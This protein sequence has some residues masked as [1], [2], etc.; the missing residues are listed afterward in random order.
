MEIKIPDKTAADLKAMLAR[1]GEDCDL[2]TYIQRTL[3]KRLLF[4]AVGEMRASTSEVDS[5]ELADAIE[6]AVTT[7]RQAHRE[8][9]P[10]ADSA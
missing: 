2:E 7:T 1:R 5:T 10:D 6:E 4:E 8:P 9:N 3:S